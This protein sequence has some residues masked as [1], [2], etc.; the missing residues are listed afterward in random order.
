MI[1]PQ[2]D[3]AA[4]GINRLFDDFIKGVSGWNSTIPPDRIALCFKGSSILFGCF[5]VFS[6]VT[7]EYVTHRCVT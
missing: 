3:D 7:D 2:H 1:G 6:C 5:S 4:S